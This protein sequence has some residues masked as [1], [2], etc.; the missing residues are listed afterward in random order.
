MM[1]AELNEP[2]IPSDSVEREMTFRTYVREFD[3]ARCYEFQSFVNVFSLLN[4]H[5]WCLVIPAQ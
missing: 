3:T 2:G 1:S 5:S 4:A